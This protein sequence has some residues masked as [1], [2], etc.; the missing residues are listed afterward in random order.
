MFYQ[1]YIL[2][3]L[4][5]G[6]NTW[7]T[8]SRSNLERLSKLQKRAARIILKASFDIPSVDMFETLGWTTIPKRHNFNKAVLVYKALNHMTP[9]YISEL[10][11]PM[12]QIQIRTLRSSTDGS[13]TVPRSTTTIFDGS[14][15][16][17]APRLWNRL[18]ESVRK[19]S[20]LNVFKRQ[21]KEHLNCV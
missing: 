16:C 2:P 7:G 12:S 3:L 4:D 21:V 11:T 8:T 13:L 5:Y 20:S 14:F 15:S 19:T 1:S 6:S 10:L 9:P 18:P 17:S